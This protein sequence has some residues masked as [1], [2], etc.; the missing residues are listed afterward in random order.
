M[1]ARCFVALLL[2]T[3]LPVPPGVALAAGAPAQEVERSQVVT[4]LQRGG[5]VIVMRH[6]S[7]P[8]TLP[9]AETAA[10]GNEQRERQLD[11]TGRETAAAMGAAAR[12]LGIPVD[13]VLTS[14]AFRTQETAREAG[15]LAPEIHEELGFDGESMTE[16]VTDEQVAW[17]QDQSRL[18]PTSGNTVIVTHSPNLAAAF[19]ELVPALAQGEAAIFGRTESGDFGLIGR[20]RIEEWPDLQ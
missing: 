9:S 8:G 17:L 19:P 2:A 10:A 7:S 4:A 6:A 13:R 20:V 5:N 14:P 15:W 11:A 16:T 3:L 1:R 18:P 12:R